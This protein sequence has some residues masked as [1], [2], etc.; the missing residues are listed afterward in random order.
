MPAPAA[1]GP[2]PPAADSPPAPA[3]STLRL[4]PTGGLPLCVGQGDGGGVDVQLRGAA[5]RREV[6]HVHGV[7]GG[8]LA[9][10]WRVAGGTRLLADVLACRALTATCPARCPSAG[11]QAKELC[12][13]LVVVPF[14]F[15]QY[16]TVSEKVRP[17]QGRKRL[18]GAHALTGA[19]PVAALANT[20]ASVLSGPLAALPAR[21]T[22]SCSATP[23]A[24]SR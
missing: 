10:R 24:S 22:A 20:A 3:A 15:E 17:G 9:V 13:H 21:C 12:P 23:P 14:L 2:R 6:W 8:G 7:C 16:Q 18:P 4:P 19:C 5:L 1:R 11:S